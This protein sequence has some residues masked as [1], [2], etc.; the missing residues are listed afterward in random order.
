MASEITGI[1]TTEGV[2]EALKELK[3]AG[4]GVAGKLH[5]YK[6]SF[7]PG[8][9]SVEAD[10]EAEEC[11]FDTYVAQA[12]TWSVVGSN[13]QG[14]AVMVSDDVVWQNVAGTSPNMVGGAWLHIDAAGPPAVDKS[15]Q[16]FPFVPPVPMSTAL[17]LIACRVYLGLP[18]FG[19]VLS[20]I[21]P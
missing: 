12:V 8:P 7:T 3:A 11:D 18:D 13:A 15:V 4:L 14:R 5:L 19:S 20:L 1:C 17:A 21:I 16:Y 6:S 2:V 10:F 9:G